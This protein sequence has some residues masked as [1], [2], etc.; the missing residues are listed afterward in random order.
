M[1]HLGAL[2]CCMEVWM[3]LSVGRSQQWTINWHWKSRA[4]HV[5]LGSNQ[6]DWGR[7]RKYEVM[8]LTG[9]NIF[10]TNTG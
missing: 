10:K 9:R 5:D 1:L 2:S 4:R 6:A 3:T 8:Q 7:D